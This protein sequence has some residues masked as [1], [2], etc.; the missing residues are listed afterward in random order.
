[1][2]YK[3]K[4][5]NKQLVAKRTMAFVFI[6]SKDFN[7]TPGQYIELPINDQVHYFSIASN[8]ETENLV[9]ATRLTGSQYK[10]DLENLPLD[11]EIEIKKPKGKFILPKNNKEIVFLVG[12][13]GITP[14][15]SMIMNDK[16][17]NFPR[18]LNL[19]YSNRTQKD[20]PFFDEFRSISNSNFNFVPTMT[21]MES[22]GGEKGYITEEMIKKH[23]KDY[24][25]PIYYIVGPPGFVKAMV[26]LLIEWLSRRREEV[27]SR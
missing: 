6:K 11:T 24:Q 8:G 13:I 25:S 4:L 1:M 14:V 2:S 5:K 3:L 17:D 26:D 22:W 23:L 15:R 9:I 19:F 10:K 12:G 21:Q 18:K 20:A 16:D 7:F 27:I